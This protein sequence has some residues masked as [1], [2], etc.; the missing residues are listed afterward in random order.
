VLAVVA[1]AACGSSSHTLDPKSL[2]RLVLQPAD[3]RG[4][5]RFENDAGTVG[6]AGVLGSRDRNGAWIARYRSPRGVVVSRIDLYRSSADAKRLFSQLRA[7]ASL[8]TGVQQIATPSVGEERVGYVTGTSLK[9]KTVFWR[10]TNA[11]GSIVVQGRDVANPDAGRLAQM[12]D[13][14]MK[15]AG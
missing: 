12:V 1:C 15:T 6:D 7:Q 9:L 14:R 11:I 5:T 10:R 13:G 2:P 3:L 4:W 8:G